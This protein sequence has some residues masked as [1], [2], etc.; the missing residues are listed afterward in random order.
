MEEDITAGRQSI[1]M[2]LDSM[3]ADHLRQ[4]DAQNAMLYRMMEVQAQNAAKLD[5]ILL[6][7]GMEDTAGKKV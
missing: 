5:R 2:L 4:V 7:A 6:A 3:K 1:V